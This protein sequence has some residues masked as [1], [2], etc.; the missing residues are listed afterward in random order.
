MRSR[1]MAVAWAHEPHSRPCGPAAAVKHAAGLQMLGS[2]AASRETHQVVRQGPDVRPLAAGDAIH[3]LLPLLGPALHLEL[4]H[5]DGPR[6]SL[7]LTPVPRQLIQLL[8][9]DFHGG[10][11]G[12]QL[13]GVPSQL[14]CCGSEV[15][16]CSSHC[17]LRPELWGQD[18][19][20]Q[21]QLVLVMVSLQDDLQV[22]C[23]AVHISWLTCYVLPWLPFGHRRVSILGCS[24]LSQPHAACT[25]VP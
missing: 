2:T 21:Q 10:V 20:T 14:C 8:P 23:C 11:H 5:M 25:E 16:I 24:S 6:L 13:H 9:P 18:V 12:S 4:G 15:R 7:N 17:L 22:Q 1:R 3:H 19:R